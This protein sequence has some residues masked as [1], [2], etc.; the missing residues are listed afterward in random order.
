MIFLILSNTF[1]HVLEGNI[2][3]LEILLA[4]VVS[5]EQSENNTRQILLFFLYLHR[6]IW[7]ALMKWNQ[8]VS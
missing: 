3:H 1:F 8:H 6:K 5:G 2:R 4:V 7:F